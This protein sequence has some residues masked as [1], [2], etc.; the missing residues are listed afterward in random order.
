MGLLAGCAL[1]QPSA[2]HGAMALE[3][4]AFTDLP[5]WGADHPATALVAFVA[6]CDRIQYFPPDQSLGGAGEAARLGGR[7]GQWGPACAAAKDVPPAD[8]AAARRFFQDRFQPYRVTK[9]GSATAT[10]TGYFEP[11]VA[12]DTSQEGPYQTPLLGLPPDLVTFDLGLFDPAQPGVT[13]VGRLQGQEILPYYDR[14]EIENGALDPG[15]LAIAWVADPVDAYFLQ[16][17]GSGRIDLPDGSVMRVT[18]AGKNGRPYVPIGRVMVRD[19]LLDA[20]DVTEQSIRAWLEAHPG[21]ARAI[22]DQNPSYVFFRTA[23]QLADAAGPLGALGVSLTPGRSIAVD[24]GFLP[25]GAPVWLAT[26]DPVSHAPLE[27]LTVAEDLGSAINGPLRADL[28]F[29]SGRAAETAAGAMDA[30]GQLYL[31]LPLPE[32]SAPSS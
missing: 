14:F 16:V 21:R 5:G 4:V 8:D 13:A 31:L 10:V 26:T 1:S 25:L 2:P 23:P 28:F 9:A 7:A 30:A 15:S 20:N 19:R 22:M 29:G 11:E 27:R 12:G 17:E 18:Y 3:P 24:Q 6:S 32:A